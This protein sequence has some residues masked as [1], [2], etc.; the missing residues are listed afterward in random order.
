MKK[1][2]IALTAFALAL[3]QG[4]AA[5]SAGKTALD[6]DQPYTAKMGPGITYDVSFDVVFTAPYGTK[7]AE[8]WLAAPIGDNAQQ[9]EAYRTEPAPVSNQKEPLYN[10]HLVY[11]SYDKPQGGQIIKQSFKVTTHELRWDLDPEKVEIVKE[12]PESFA[13]YLRNEEKVVVDENAKALARK[14]VGEEKNPVRQSRLLMSYIMKT[15]NYDHTTCSLQASSVW[16]LDKKVGHCS[17]YHGLATA[18]AR[19]V[20]IP[21]RVT[22]GINPIPKNSPTHCKSEFYFAGYGWVSFDI[23]E[24]QK[25]VKKIEKDTTLDDAG[26]GEKIKSV[27]DRFEKGFRDNT[28]YKVTNGTSYPL[29]PATKSGTPALVRTAVIEADGKPLQDPDPGNA[30][31]REFAWMTI[32][33][34]NPSTP[35]EY[36]FK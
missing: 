3:H 19:A 20:N 16:A 35:V 31:L 18:L 28:W 1:S 26:K 27:M 12:W 10:N 21:A 9:V 14:I 8:V 13:R 36:P 23:S 11:F 5:E 25:V 4:I 2:T 15:L 7:Q 33:N 17:D 30:N 22:Y 32:T 29:V 6:P 24:T 34:F